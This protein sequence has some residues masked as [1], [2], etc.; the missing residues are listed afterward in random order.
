MEVYED[1]E[2]IQKVSC[3]YCGT[4]CLEEELEELGS[5]LICYDCARTEEKIAEVIDEFT[6]AAKELKRL[7]FDPSDYLEGL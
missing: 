4:E 2:S 6:W 7:G 3:D 1:D 5:D